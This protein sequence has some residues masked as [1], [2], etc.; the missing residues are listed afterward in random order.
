MQPAALQRHSLTVL[1]ANPTAT[2]LL[3]HYFACELR[4]SDCYLLYGSVGA[5]KSYFRCVCASHR[6]TC[7]HTHAALLGAQ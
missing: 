7:R 5:G 4:S 6:R 3:A 2:Q 1:A